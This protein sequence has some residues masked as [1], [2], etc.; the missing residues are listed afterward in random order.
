MSSRILVLVHG[1]LKPAPGF[2][3]ADEVF[4]SVNENKTQENSSRLLG[5]SQRSTKWHE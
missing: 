3:E 2:T 4:V 5:H 1:G